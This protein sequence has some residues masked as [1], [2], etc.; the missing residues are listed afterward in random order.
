[1]SCGSH[2]GG[3]MARYSTAIILT[4]G[5]GL[6]LF[7]VCYAR[8][9]FFIIDEA[10]YLFAADTFRLSGRFI[11]F[12]GSDL[13][14]ST[15]LLWTNLLSQ[16][17]EGITSQYPPGTTL[18]WAPL[19]SLFG[20]RSIIVLNTVAT[21]GAAFATRGLA[22]RLFGN[23][24]VALGACL[25]LLFGTF[26]LEYAF[27]YWPHMVS[28]WTIVLAFN[29]F[30]DAMDDRRGTLLPAALSGLVLGT[31][32]VFRL[33]N[34]LLLPVFAVLTVMFAGRPVRLIAGG[35]LGVVPALFLLALVNYEKFGKFNPLSYGGKS[36]LT[37]IE[38]YLP[39]AAVGFV[40]LGALTILRL[41]PPRGRGLITVAFGAAAAL[42]VAMATVPALRDFAAGYG[43]GSYRLM[44]DAR[45]SSNTPAGIIPMSDGTTLFWGLSKKALGQSLPW[46]GVLLLLTAPAAWRGRSRSVVIILVFV[47]IFSFPFAAVAWHGGMSSNMRYFLPLVPFASVLAAVLIG[48]LLAGSSRHRRALVLAIPAGVAAA[49]TWT[50][51]APTGLAGTH[52][53]WSLYLFAAV[54]ALALLAA[55]SRR[56]GTSL[57]AL[58]ACGLGI[59]TAA[60]NGTSDTLLSQVRRDGARVLTDLS[61][62]FAGKVLIYD[63]VLRSALVDPEQVVALRSRS[64]AIPDEKLVRAALDNG[65]RV[66]MR[67]DWA[68]EFTDEHKGYGWRDAEGPVDVVEVFRSER[69]S[70]N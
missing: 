2:A 52:Q 24:S 65:Y 40:A 45:N 15:D 1:M 21:I 68:A 16:G 56:P 70:S 13:G 8:L 48:D 46:L 3:K 11:L 9:G 53:K 38:V 42:V 34:V 37:N 47:L 61:K 39:F 43:V 18:V 29:L 19:L 33:D 25:L 51:A 31:G 50:L 41:R 67:D 60:F 22:L 54:A 6:I 63:L 36:G 14:P 59:G 20:E 12:N 27:A 57:A 32:M 44:V 26:T 23:P 28:V 5:A 49:L 58:I 4:F 69:L 30:L 7:A 62:Q 55:H 17:P 35:A 64:D 66:L 10:I